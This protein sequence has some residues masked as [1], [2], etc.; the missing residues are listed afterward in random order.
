MRRI[1]TFAALAAAG[2]ATGAQADEFLAVVDST[3][4]AVMLFDPMDG[5]L[6]NP[7]Y[8]DGAGVFSTPIKAIRVEEEIWISDQL[9]DTIFRYDLDGGALGSITGGMD[10]IRG[11]A[12]IGGVVYVCNSGE[13][14]GTAP[15]DA[16]VMFDAAGA[17]MGSFPVGDPFD[18]IEFGGNLLVANI[19]DENL[20]LHDPSGTFLSTFHDS[21][22]VTGID[23][24]EQLNLKANGNVI[25][26]GFSPP[27]GIYEY[28]KDTG[29]QVNYIDVGSAVRGV[30][31]LGNGNIMWTDGAGVHILDISTGGSTLVA[32]ASGRF[33]TLID[34]TSGGDCYAD[35]DGDTILDF[36][37]F[38]CFQNEFAAGCP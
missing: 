21:D 37:D 16:L 14:G 2:L 10:N 9:A 20:D 36:F 33:I 28:D 11:L 35:C 12:Y 31:E 4:D 5:T 27:A 13:G 26:G 1:C 17:P 8:I 38:L 25:A 18:V 6:V 23:F 24:P 3:A 32:A 15:G 34:T 7:L 30:Y 29:D 22:G 19:A